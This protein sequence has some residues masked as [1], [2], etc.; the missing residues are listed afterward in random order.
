MLGMKWGGGVQPWI[1]VVVFGEVKVRALCMVYSKERFPQSHAGEQ[2]TVSLRRSPSLSVVRS[3]MA[4]SCGGKSYCR[5][6]KAV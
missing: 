3:P 4:G 2:D 6:Q 1:Y 5:G